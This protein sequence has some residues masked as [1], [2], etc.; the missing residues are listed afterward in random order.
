MFRRGVAQLL[1][2]LLLQP[3]MLWAHAHAGISD[4]DPSGKV[5]PPH[6]HL[7][8]LYSLWQQPGEDPHYPRQTMALDGAR[9]TPEHDADAVYLPISI[10]LG[11]QTGPQ[12]DSIVPYLIPVG[13]IN[14]LPSA[15]TVGPSEP[16]FLLPISSQPCLIYLCAFALLI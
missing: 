10:L 6:F 2:A 8:F 5:R 12:V 13:V 1:V 11:W 7:R 3:G 9:T 14:S 16:A 4:H 15:S